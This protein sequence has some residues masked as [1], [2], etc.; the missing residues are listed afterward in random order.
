[1]SF[2]AFAWALEQDAGD[3]A[4]KCLLLCLAHHANESGLAWPSQELLASESCQSV[5]TVQR[6]LRRLEHR[7]QIRR[8]PLRF[9]GRRSV[10]LVVFARST[11]WAASRDELRPFLPRGHTFLSQQRSPRQSTAC[12]P[13]LPQNGTAAAS[14][15]PQPIRNAAALLRQQELTSELTIERKSRSER[16]AAKDPPPD[17]Q[18]ALD[19]F[20]KVWPS[21][22]VDSLRNTTDAWNGLTPDERRLAI[23]RAPA[24]LELNRSLGRTHIPA[25]ATFLNDK[26]WVQ[27]TAQSEKEFRVA[28]R[29]SREWWWFLVKRVAANENVKSMLQAA[30]D[31]HGYTGKSSAWLLI[32]AQ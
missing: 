19:A 26:R 17:P 12:A 24:W 14:T 5:D 27:L 28:R 29:Y 25:A 21:A 30:L 10:D 1:M 18:S 4:A 3:A 8:V 31:G 23:E 20:L 13:T 16:E 15:L 6:G 9:E 22:N 2:A 7:G 32:G 11:L